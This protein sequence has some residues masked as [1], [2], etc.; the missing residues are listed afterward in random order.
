MT[1]ATAEKVSK[2]VPYLHLLL[3]DQVTL[4]D[5]VIPQALVLHLAQ[6]GQLDLSRPEEEQR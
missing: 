5:Q 1:C 6:Q 4:Q 2:A 3:V